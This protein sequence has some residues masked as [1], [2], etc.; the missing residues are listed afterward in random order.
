MTVSRHGGALLLTIFY[1]LCASAYF[2]V[3]NRNHN[4]FKFSSNRQ[5]SI[6]LNSFGDP[7]LS[8]KSNAYRAFQEFARFWDYLIFPEEPDI[9][10]VTFRSPV[11]WA[12][13]METIWFGNIYDYRAA[14]FHDVMYSNNQ[15]C[16]EGALLYKDA[17]RSLQMALLYQRYKRFDVSSYSLSNAT[18]FNIFGGESM[19]VGRYKV[20]LTEEVILCTT[21]P[22]TS[23]EIKRYLN[24]LGPFKWFKSKFF[25]QKRKRQYVLR[26]SSR[27]DNKFSDYNI[28]QQSNFFRDAIYLIENGRLGMSNRAQETSITV[29]ISPLSN[30]IADTIRI[31]RAE[32]PLTTITTL[33]I[34]LSSANSQYFLEN[35]AQSV[36]SYLKIKGKISLK[37]STILVGG[38]GR[39]LNDFAFEVISRVATGNNVHSVVF[40]S[41]AILATPTAIEYMLA[42]QSASDSRASKIAFVLSAA[43]S[44]GGLQG[45]FGMQV[46]SH[47]IL[48]CPK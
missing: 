16:R 1:A 14:Y 23:S 38:D 42:T 45:D 29:P 22:L 46:D 15:P 40:S 19:R 44:A 10:G 20:P 41:D 21:D 5:R 28:R 31:R 47:A 7:D 12:P 2:H 9:P 4:N 27:K 18:F 11:E 8:W 17:Y 43:D 13:W 6:R 3:G 30:E 48:M 37:R 34:P 32:P 36:L 39:L 33:Q 35:L 25:Q 26:L 24:S